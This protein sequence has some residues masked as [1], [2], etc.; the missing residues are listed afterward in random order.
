MAQTLA[1]HHTGLLAT[2]NVR[3]TSDPMEGTNRTTKTLKRYASGFRG[4]EFFQL[5][6]L[7]LHETKSELVG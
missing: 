6:I 1:A 5:K 4:K 2:Y 7:A 3:N